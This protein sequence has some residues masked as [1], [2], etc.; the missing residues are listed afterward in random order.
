MSRKKK[1]IRGV[2]IVWLIVPETDKQANFMKRKIPGKV[3]R[4]FL[5]NGLDSFN[6]CDKFGFW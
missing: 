1:D 2:A 4:D 3:F 6:P 5:N